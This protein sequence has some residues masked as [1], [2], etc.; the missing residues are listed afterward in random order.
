VLVQN[1]FRKSIA[2]IGIDTVEG[3]SP[4][5]TGF[6]AS[7]PGTQRYL[8]TARH[9][10]AGIAEAGQQIRIRFSQEAGGV[11][12]ATG[13]WDKWR[14]HPRSN[15]EAVDIAVL[16]ISI[17]RSE[18]IYAHVPLPG[19]ELTTELSKELQVGVGDEV[20]V[21]GLFTSH[22]G[23]TKNVPIVRIGNIALMPE[24]PVKTKKQGYI[25]A[26]LIEARSIAGLSGSPV[27]IHFPPY[28]H[29][30]NALIKASVSIPM[31]LGVMHGHFDTDPSALDVVIED[32]ASRIGVHTGIG[33]VTP[34]SKVLET[35]AALDL[36][37]DANI[38]VELD[39]AA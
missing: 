6:I 13:P 23:Q 26:Y 25:E 28:R 9:V 8:V 35:L 10:V 20:F 17:R 2:F 27:F 5:G 19:A 38:A 4:R 15:E 31:L 14:F 29:V 12:F 30:K 3:F 1:V 22:Y 21:V 36:A 33:V 24:E 18:T 11:G 7:L 39:A 34:V 32:R 37:A 16:P